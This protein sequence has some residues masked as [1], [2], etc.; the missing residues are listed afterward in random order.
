MS[1]VV[2]ITNFVEAKKEELHKIIDPMIECILSDEVYD[3]GIT[4]DEYHNARRELKRLEVL[5]MSAQERF[6]EFHPEREY[7]LWLE[8]EDAMRNGLGTDG[9]EVFENLDVNLFLSKDKLPPQWNGVDW[10]NDPQTWVDMQVQKV[11]NRK[12]LF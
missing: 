2:S 6:L 5:E 1:N 9:I 7:E 8:W 11:L 10:R 3:P 4:W 12:D